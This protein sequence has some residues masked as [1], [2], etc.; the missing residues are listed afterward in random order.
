[1]NPN[2]EVAL[3]TIIETAVLAGWLALALAGDIVLSIVVLAVGL[4]VEHLTA[5]NTGT[6]QPFWRFPLRRP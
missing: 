3:F 2:V 1:M 6:A 5:F 4:F